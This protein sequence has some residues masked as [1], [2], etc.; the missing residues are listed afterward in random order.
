MGNVE[1]QERDV[2]PKLLLPNFK[3]QHY[4]EY[5]PKDCSR[6]ESFIRR[7]YTNI[8]DRLGFKTYYWRI[9]HLFPAKYRKI[10]DLNFLLH[11]DK[12]HSGKPSQRIERIHYRL[13]RM[14]YG[15]ELNFIKSAEL[16]EWQME[17]S[18]D[19]YLQKDHY[20][21]A[22][23]QKWLKNFREDPEWKLLYHGV[24][25]YEIIP[26]IDKTLAKLYRQKRIAEKAPSSKEA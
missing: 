10:Y 20:V 15:A 5:I 1:L 4:Q 7:K 6:L 24:E 14:K 12:D 2:E 19:V 17:H 26:Y 18:K 9:R 3:G 16:A 25:A 13:A 23:R 11:V 21:K 8:L 22:Y